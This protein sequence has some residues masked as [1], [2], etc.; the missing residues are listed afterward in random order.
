MILL[1]LQLISCLLLVKGKMLRISD[2][3]RLTR[4]LTHQARMII[5]WLRLLT[6]P[7]WEGWDTPTKASSI[8][9]TKEFPSLPLQQDLLGQSPVSE[10]LLVILWGWL[11]LEMIRLLER[12]SLPFKGDFLPKLSGSTY[13]IPGGKDVRLLQVTPLKI[14]N[15][16]H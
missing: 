8:A 14:I 1:Y 9:L 5:C 15:I 4:D 10:A 7:W 16:G 2:I 3:S 12:F 11:G 13:K 6:D